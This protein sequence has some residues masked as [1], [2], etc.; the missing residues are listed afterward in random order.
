MDTN[1]AML[2]VETLLVTAS[3][4]SLNTSTGLTEELQ[5]LS[6]AMPR[7]VIERLDFD[8]LKP[9]DAMGNFQ[10]RGNFQAL[11]KAEV[12]QSITPLTPAD[13]GHKDLGNSGPVDLMA[14]AQRMREELKSQIAGLNQRA[15]GALLQKD[16]SL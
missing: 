8:H 7:A 2:P 4:D 3:V 5:V 9:S 15:G 11:R 16:Q 1:F 6:V 14:K 13:I 12:F 10:I